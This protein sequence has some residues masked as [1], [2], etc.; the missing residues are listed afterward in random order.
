MRRTF[1]GMLSQGL[2]LL[3]PHVANLPGLQLGDGEQTAVDFRMTPGAAIRRSL[4]SGLPSCSETFMSYS[5]WRKG[6]IRRWKHETGVFTLA[7]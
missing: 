2:E 6:C 7:L 4:D 5:H 1:G 3:F